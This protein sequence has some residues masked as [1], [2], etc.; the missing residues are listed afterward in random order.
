MSNDG[1]VLLAGKELS[2]VFDFIS[3]HQCSSVAPLNLPL[4]P[5][6]REVGINHDARGANAR[7]EMKSRFRAGGHHYPQAFWF[8]GDAYR[9]ERHRRGEFVFSSQLFELAGYDE[10]ISAGL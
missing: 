7:F 10:R 9:V 5:Q 6:Q 2:F 4:V 1:V 8:S 3:V